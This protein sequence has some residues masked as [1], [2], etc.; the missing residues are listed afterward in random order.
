MTKILKW[1][2]Y[3]WLYLIAI[4]I[5]NLALL[6]LPLTNVFG[7]EFSVINSLLLVLLSGIYTIYFYKNNFEKHQPDFLK[8][9]LQ[10]LFLFLLIPFCVSVFNSIITGFCSFTDGILFYLVITAPSIL[11]GTSLGLISILLLSRFQI[12]LLLLL[13]IGILAII[14]F[15]IYFNPQVYIFNPILGFFPGT[16]YDEGIAVTGK[17]VI[18]RVLNLLFFTF[19][20]IAAMRS[21][22]RGKKK[23]VIT[24]I[25]IPIVIAGIF[26]LLSPQFGFSTTFN[27]LKD[28]LDKTIVS[29]HFIIHSD[30][31]IENKKIKM[32]AL[33]HE[34][35]YQELEKYFEVSLDEKIH[36]FIFY[37]ND[38][39]KELLGSRNADIAKPWLNQIYITYDNWDH[40][41]KHELAHCFSA[42]FGAGILKLASGLNPMLIEGIAEAADGN[43]NDNSLH[44]MAA[45]AFNSGYT[46]D[47]EYLLSKIGFYSQSSSISYIY[48]GSF[49]QYLIENYGII[50]FKKYYITGD[51]KDSYGVE[52]S[53]TLALYY[54][55]L[56]DLDYTFSEDKASYYF[57]RKSIFQ[58]VCPR[59]IAKYLRTGWEQMHNMQFTGAQETFN[60]ILDKSD[61][62]SAFVGLIRSY[63]KQDSISSAINILKKN[64]SE[65]KKTSYYYNL[66]L[67]LADLFLKIGEEKTADSLYRVIIKQD[68]NK[69]L[70]SI[71]NIRKAIL[72]D[73]INTDYL[74]GSNY[75]KY[76]FLQQMNEDHYNYWTFPV[77]INLSEVLDEHYNIFLKNFNKDIKVQ[78]YVSSYASFLLS[79]YMLANYDFINAKKIAGL[80]LRYSSDSNLNI[81]LKEQFNKA[82]WFAMNGEELL[83]KFI[84]YYK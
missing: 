19:I 71:S 14:A 5:I 29:E 64:I 52:L 51:Y 56:A 43:Y 10:S 4:F 57:G 8:D 23:Y 37:D 58:K 9:V 84:I 59:A 3:L 73:E 62:Y 27:R 74:L 41:L 54:K 40:T 65:Y 34:Y 69:R 25:V 20:I 49:I 45:L 2:N 17:L 70:T 81:I 50:K 66:E 31:R 26:Y 38:Q 1:R 67:I 32:L 39:K 42:D 28:E 75:D 21:L 15:E 6:K 13:Y 60:T 53:N 36:A 24:T 33:N 7:Y 44:F 68:P 22:I 18:Y 35:Y 46:M 11:I 83:G 77:I 12:V 61:N 76:Y 16:I 48:A 63:E 79:K 30:R 78:D 82:K 47:L 55:F 72:N 80:S